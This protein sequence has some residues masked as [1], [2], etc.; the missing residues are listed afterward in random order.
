LQTTLLGIGIALIL[1][2]VAALV[3]PFFV[4]WSQY[5]TAFEA[6]ASRLVGAPVRINGRIDARLLPT[7]SVTLR[8]VSTDSAGAEPRLKVG[9][10]AVELA[11]GPLMRGEWRAAEL[12][13]ARPE[14]SLEIDAGGRLAWSGGT[15]RINPEAL[16]IDRLTIEDGRATIASEA[17]AARY[18]AEGFWFQGDVRSLAGPYKG[19][20]GF[21]AAGTQYGFRLATGRLGEDGIRVKVG[22]DPDRALSVEAD[23]MLRVER[24]VPG[25]EGALTLARPAVAGGGTSIDPW[26][27]VAR[28]TATA[29]GALF[30]HV[31]VQYGPDDR[32]VK[33]TGT[34]ELKLGKTPSFQAVASARQIDLDRLLGLSEETRR[35]PVAVA[36]AFNEAFGEA[37]RPPLPVRISLAADVVTVAGAGL[38][39]LRGDLVGDGNSWDLQS[40]EFRAPG[41]A[42]IRASGRLAVGAA[43]FGFSGPASVD[44][45]DPQALLAW[46]EGRG[47]TPP[48]RPTRLQAN[49][50]LTLGGEKVAIERVAAEID[51]KRLEGR[52]V[53][54]WPSASRAA[55][56][57]ADIA[58]PELDFDGALAFVRSALGGT[59][60]DVPSD[61]TLALDIGVATVAGVQAKGLKGKLKFD[62][63]GIV[64]DR[65][66]VADLGGA[67]VELAG[68]IDGLAETPH[69][70]VTADLDA[71]TL[72][73]I[74]A[75][76]AKFAPTTV[77]AVQLAASKLAS[78]K[79]RAT[80]TLDPVGRDAGT[81]S[82]KVTITGRA[83]PARVSIVA[84]ASGA[85]SDPAAADIKL[86]T[87]LEA[88]NG[89][90]LASL[91]GL[92][93]G[94]RVDRSPGALHLDAAGR[95]GGDVRLDGWLRLGGLNLAAKGT[96][97]PT[98]GTRMGSL[99]VSLAASDVRLPDRLKGDGVP[100]TLR[101][102]LAVAPDAVA[103][104][105]LN[106]TVANSP[107]RGE[108][109][110]K[111]GQAPQVEGRLDTDA[112]DAIAF[113]TAI[114]GAPTGRKD[115]T[116]WS[117]EP[118]AAGA[119]AGLSGQIELTAAH[120]TLGN[121]LPASRVRA[122]LRLGPEAALENIDA[123]VAGGRLTG[124]VALRHHADGLTTSANLTLANGDLAILMPGDTRPPVTG[125]ATLRVETEGT[126]R[127]PAALAGAL[128]GNGTLS[129]EQAQF[130]GLDPRAF[131]VATR[132]VDQG[133]ALDAA[134]IKDTIVAGLDIARLIV[135]RAEGAFAIDAGQVRWATLHAPADGAKLT[136]TGSVDLA[137][138]L[139]DLRLTLAGPGETTGR[140]DIYIAVRG[141]L[142]T[143][144]RTVDASAL[145]GWLMLRAVEREARRLE[146][147][148]SDR[149]EA[150][151]PAEPAAPVP[152]PS[153]AI[154]TAPP[155]EPAAVPPARPSTP[156]P[157][158][159][160]NAAAPAR[161][162]I[163]AAPDFPAPI[164]IRP[165]P[166]QGTSGT[167]AR[168]PAKS[169]AP[170]PAPKPQAAAPQPVP[171][172]RPP[173]DLGQ[174]LG[175][176]VLDLLSG[177]QR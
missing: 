48:A 62:A 120:A 59:K 94:F 51:R 61:V 5:R 55:R 70:T 73:G 20:G 102:K 109:L 152:A 106:G 1:A 7:P 31:E 29:A 121:G 45:R 98:S 80:L 149:Q 93:P 174:T 47:A 167:G 8:E 14:V 140:P 105:E 117:A 159:P 133:V 6:Q 163:E 126:G 22:L 116:A 81:Q 32:A 15:P 3:G 86:T 43:G 40:L 165:G 154:R 124:R 119:L 78:A 170:A 84:E 173:A 131:E 151:P 122:L 42:D 161:T 114:A 113:V 60:L 65:I 135:P 100:V 39:N 54:T 153:A 52:L 11:L 123:E 2:L 137:Q 130:A 30:D 143:P 108:L 150:R 115:G 18:V 74:A 72:D 91:V 175:R 57:D 160:R 112:V 128:R 136:M 156:A 148:Q 27:A 172:P 82:A 85:L 4:D 25:F 50:E 138:W 64:L 164:E 83:G 10:V 24:G 107:L 139:T 142:F 23:G 33:L 125:R 146:V 144:A 21:T 99:E 63:D 89:A 177:P 127:S 36:R 53:Y 88:Q 158:A 66:A 34:A 67:A 17:N 38:Q 26:R 157:P 96:L 12:R 147:L 101:T 13:L 129:V 56:L 111:G 162:V 19:E 28:V 171:L 68:R 103:L 141:P 71:R 169:A 92:S 49:G 37:A 46:L 97:S 145:T 76:L 155:E 75:V 44:A 176:S 41:L 134:K 87:R 79:L 166:G 132:A 104:G 95:L 110:I 35:L 9:E 58:A 69:G 168:K 90:E 77:D 118:F 16:S